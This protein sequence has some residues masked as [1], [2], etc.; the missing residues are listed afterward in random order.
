MSTSAVY[1]QILWVFA[2]QALAVLGESSGSDGWEQVVA[3]VWELAKCHSQSVHG[4]KGRA[5]LGRAGQPE[6]QT[7]EP[8]QKAAGWQRGRFWRSQVTFL[9]NKLLRLKNKRCPCILYRRKCKMIYS[10]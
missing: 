2:N 4:S 8:M 9:G 10:P 7:G 6:D 1:C 3:T 5:G